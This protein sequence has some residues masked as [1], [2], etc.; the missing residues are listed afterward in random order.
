MR[1]KNGNALVK[2]EEFVLAAVLSLH[3]AGET[4]YHGYRVNKFLEKH[5]EKFVASTLYRILNR[6]EERGYL[7]SEWARPPG[8]TQWRCLFALTPE[9]T[10]TA[11]QIIA[12][13]E[14][15]DSGVGPYPFAE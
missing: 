5:D 3:N 4:E 15:D 2:K 8:S 13:A 10:T 6:L 1:R 14:V 7:T 12:E 9:G 11:E